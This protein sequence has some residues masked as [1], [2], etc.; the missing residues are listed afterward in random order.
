MPEDF[1][2]LNAAKIIAGDFSQKPKSQSAPVVSSA[3]LAGSRLIASEDRAANNPSTG[4]R[5]NIAHNVANGRFTLI[6]QDAR[7]P[8]PF[9]GAA[10]VILN[11]AS[12]PK[13]QIGPVQTFKTSVLGAMNLLG[14]L[15]RALIALFDSLFRTIAWPEQVT[16]LAGRTQVSRQK[17]C[18]L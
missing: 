4:R 17:G 7:G 10:D 16:R 18:L 15:K 1:K 14:N 8:A 11:P 2:N 9:A 6:R 12:P 3:G 13:H 5:T